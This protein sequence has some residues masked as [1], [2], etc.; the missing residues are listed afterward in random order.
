M[1]VDTETTGLDP[2]VDRIIE[3]GVVT[4]DGGA[5]DEWTTLLNPRTPRALTSRLLQEIGEERARSLP[6]FGEIARALL[7]RVGNGLLI[8]H[9]A[10]FDYAFLRA[11]FERAGIRF[12]AEVVCSLMLSKRLYG[13]RGRHDLASLV[14]RHALDSATRHRALPDAQALYQLW[15][16]FHREHSG[17]HIETAIRDLLAEPVLPAAARFRTARSITGQA[18]RLR[19]PR[20][21]GSASCRTCEKPQAAAYEPLPTRSHLEPVR[22]LDRFDRGHH[23]AGRER[24]SR[25]AI[26]TSGDFTSRPAPQAP[27]RKR[28]ELLLAFRPAS[29]P[30]ARPGSALRS[31]GIRR[32]L[33]RDISNGAQGPQRARP[34]CHA[35]STVPHA[36]GPARERGRGLRRVSSRIGR[37]ETGAPAASHAGLCGALAMEDRAVAVRGTDRHQGAPRPA[38]GGPLALSWNG[39]EHAGSPRTT[40]EPAARLR[41]GC[42]FHSAPDA[43]PVA[44]PASGA[45]GRLQAIKK[46]G[47]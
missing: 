47:F 27:A 44:A 31:R 15:Q 5:V 1:F 23:L 11:E 25:C 45:A 6:R 19:A 8:A 10:R 7:Q 13:R 12:E 21:G 39:A 22:R 32:R 41:R 35:P 34:P 17:A 24:R 40:R 28:R 9:N 38:R 18:G 29:P 46:R 14:E 43:L 36:A 4:V 2:A 20:E 3:I 16:A 30:R 26:A 37:R 42:L 33:V